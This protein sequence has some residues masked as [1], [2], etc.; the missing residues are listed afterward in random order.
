[1][2]KTIFP[3]LLACLCALPACNTGRGLS[4]KVMKA[5]KDGEIYFAQTPSGSGLIV[6]P[7]EIPS[8]FS[9]AYHLVAEN[10]GKGNFLENLNALYNIPKGLE[11]YEFVKEWSDSTLVCKISD[12]SKEVY[13]TDTLMGHKE[14]Y[15]TYGEFKKSSIDMHKGRFKFE[16]LD[17]QNKIKYCDKVFETRFLYRC[18]TLTGNKRVQICF[19]K[20]SDKMKLCA[21][22]SENI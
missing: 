5:I 13:E 9:M 21:I 4:E 10:E 2:K 19:L 1:M 17:N 11:S 18:K 22:F 16:F 20:E 12:I 15:K 6:I 7:N 3:F 14:M 8:T